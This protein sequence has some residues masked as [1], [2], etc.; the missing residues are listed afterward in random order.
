MITNNS[1]EIEI[2]KRIEKDSLSWSYLLGVLILTML[3]AI[4]MYWDTVESIGKIWWR[5]DTYAHGILIAPISM[6]MIYGRRK[7]IVSLTPAI[8]IWGLVVLALLTLTWIF[9]HAA[10]VLF[11]QQLTFVA[12]IIALVLLLLGTAVMKSILFPLAYLFFMVPIGESLT[13]IMQDFTAVFT[14]R[15]LQ[16]T[17]VPVFLEGLYF[18]IPTGN[19]EVAE[20]CSGVRYLIASVALGCLYAYVYYRSF[21]KRS[22]FIAL[23][24]VVPLIANVIRAYGIVMLAYVSDM[25]LAVGVDHLIYG[26]LFFGLVMF[27]LFWIGSRWRDPP[28]N[29]DETHNAPVCVLKNDMPGKRKQV[30]VMI[31]TICLMAAGP[32]AAVW[33]ER[34][35]VATPR[36]VD[37]LALDIK[38]PW[39]GINEQ[40]DSW[41][42]KYQ[43]ADKYLR[44]DYRTNVNRKMYLYIA[45]YAGESEDRELISSQNAIYDGKKWV[46]INEGKRDIYLKTGE[47]LGVV[48][49][50]IR[51]RDKKRVVWH[52]YLISAKRTADKLTAK[53]A[54]AW[55]RLRG[56]HRGAAV[57][58]IAVDYLDTPD[59]AR[60]TLQDFTEDNSLLWN[61][62]DFW[63]L[64]N[65]NSELAT[66]P[67]RADVSD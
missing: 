35:K 19:F 6:Y 40:T 42:P 36:D 9:A 53:L 31:A 17:G 52:W 2:Q 7:H 56:A 18:S 13:P 39:Y 8:N 45:Y 10:N 59:Q 63:S 67:K 22:L 21:L 29:N 41:I 50:L 62:Q 65:V 24:V 33:I 38:G 48:E 32:T 34:N 54:E 46:R 47:K 16:F 20:A 28:I 58:A 55:S 64:I 15:L 1:T 27:F 3:F 14:V 25:K 4:G 51:S 23:C 37:I 60:K 61:P 49:T 44:R 66:L 26:W 5:S 57:V 12:M 43:G 30:L 11:V